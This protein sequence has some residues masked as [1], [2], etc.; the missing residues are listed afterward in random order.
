[1]VILGGGA[2]EREAAVDGVEDAVGVGEEVLL[3]LRRG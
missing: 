3:E 2:L 1:M